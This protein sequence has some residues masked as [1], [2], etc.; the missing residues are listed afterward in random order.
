MLR[1][2]LLMQSPAVYD[3]VVC[4]L[5]AH[6]A[7]TLRALSKRDGNKKVLGLEQA[8][9]TSQTHGSSHGRSR[10]I[11]TGYFEDPAYVPL[12]IESFALWSELE[13]ETVAHSTVEEKVNREKILELTGGLM[14]GD[15]ES[16]VIQGTL[17]AV[18]EHNLPHTIMSPEEVRK[19]YKGMLQLQENEIGEKRCPSLSIFPLIAITVTMMIILT[20]CPHASPYSYT[21][22]HHRYIRGAGWLRRPRSR[23]RCVH[24]FC[25]ATQ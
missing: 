17:T 3:Y 11:R 23:S 16:E 7:S 12:L 18:S 24:R 2:R 1:S 5:G 25:S 20:Q 22:H 14:I 19:K 8:S 15:P 21:H 10:I 6:G 4:G 9:R 13:D